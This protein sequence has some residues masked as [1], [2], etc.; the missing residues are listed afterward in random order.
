MTTTMISNIM[1]SSLLLFGSHDVDFSAIWKK[2]EGEWS[3]VGQVKEKKQIL[4]WIEK[5]PKTPGSKIL[6]IEIRKMPFITLLPTGEVV[7][8]KPLQ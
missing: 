7:N 1:L 5:I 2:V 8:L 3:Y 6:N 4:G